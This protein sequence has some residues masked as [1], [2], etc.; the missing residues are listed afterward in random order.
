VSSGQT[1]RRILAPF[2]SRPKLIGR[3]LGR[4]QIAGLAFAR[5]L[6]GQ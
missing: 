2:E 6:I 4:G 1:S 3:F 5:H